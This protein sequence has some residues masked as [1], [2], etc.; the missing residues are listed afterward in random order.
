MDSAL[1]RLEFRP[2]ARGPLDGVRV[3]DISRLVAGNAISHFLADYGADVLKV[4]APGRGDD[5]RAWKTNE[6][7]T[8]WKLYGRNKKS[9]TLDFRKGRGRELLLQLVREADV[10]IENF[11]PG[12]LEQME[13]GPQQLHA[14]N[15]KLVVVRVSGW[16]QTGPFSHKPGFGTLVEAMSGFA[17][18]SGFPDRPPVLP[19]LALADLVSGLHGVSAVLIAL[20]HVEVSGGQGQVIDLSLFDPMLTLLG[21]EAATARLTGQATRRNGSRASNTAP[22]NIYACSD[23]KFVALSASMQSM[24][25]KLFNVMGRPDLITDPRFRTNTDRVRNMDAID[26]LVADFILRRTQ[27]ENL[28]LFDAAGVTVGPVADAIDLMQHPYVAARESLVELPDAQMGTVPQYNVPA[29]LSA[30]PGAIRT[31]APELGQHNAEIF[32]RLGVDA[33]ELERLKEQ[34]IV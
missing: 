25:E 2:D 9:V 30:T 20:R 22:R 12:K 3:V 11:V 19:P 4:E 27:A 15:P 16:G 13:L 17:A 18:L 6:V 7:A 24:A 23:G 21:P 10:V 33:V 31:P 1:H 28:A 8:W 14:A 29:R 5:L 34:G 32:A 26:T